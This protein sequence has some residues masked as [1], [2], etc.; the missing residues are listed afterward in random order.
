MEL[1]QSELTDQPRPAN[2]IIDVLDEAGISEKTRNRAK[3]RLMLKGVMAPPRNEGGSWY[4]RL[5]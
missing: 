1:L 2:E 3:S 5:A 4:W